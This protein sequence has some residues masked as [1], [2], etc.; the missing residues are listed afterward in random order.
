MSMSTF[1]V[2]LID[3][4]SIQ[5]KQHCAVLEACY[6]AGVDLP[7]QTRDFFGPAYLAG[8]DPKYTIREFLQKDLKH[9]ESNADGENYFDVDVASI[10]PEVKTIRF[11]NSY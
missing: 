4:N 9:S 3:R 5:F 7:Q 1:V 2:G 11:V 8:E 6:A 10:P